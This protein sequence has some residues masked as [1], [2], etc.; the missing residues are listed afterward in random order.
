MNGF[1]TQLVAQ[2]L[3]ASHRKAGSRG[4][5]LKSTHFMF[6]ENWESRELWQTHMNAALTASPL[7]NRAAS[8]WSPGD[9]TVRNILVRR[10]FRP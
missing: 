2:T 10:R 1:L 6:N 8:A 9:F 5:V 7:S 3:G 4:L